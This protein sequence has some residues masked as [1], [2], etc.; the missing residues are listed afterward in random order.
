MKNVIGFI[1]LITVLSGCGS[2]VE[3][4]KCD[5]VAGNGDKGSRF[6]KIDFENNAWEDERGIEP[7][8][9]M[10]DKLYHIRDDGQ[11]IT[12]DL[13]TGEWVFDRKIYKT[14]A[15]CSKL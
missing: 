6:M 1:P 4:W 11:T 13:K 12:L 10:G 8:K 15:K 5:F 7:F 3:T 14:R 9:K 2:S